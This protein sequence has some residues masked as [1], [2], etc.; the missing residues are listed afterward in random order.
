[1]TQQSHTAETEVRTIIEA[2]ADAVRRHDY[3]GVLDHHDQDI[4]MF[5]VPPPFQSRGLDEYRKTWD[6]FFGCQR[7]SYAFNIEDIAITAG[8]DVAFAVAVMRCGAPDATFQFRLT[9][10]LRKIDGSWR[11]THEHHSVPATD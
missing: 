11:I 1:M 5:D 7:P 4:V 2:W 9:I 6:L 8:D 10:G 3:A